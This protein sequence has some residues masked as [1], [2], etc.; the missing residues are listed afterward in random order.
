[1]ASLACD[2][3]VLLPALLSWHHAHTRCAFA[4]AQQ[5]FAVPAHVLMETF[6]VLTRLPGNRISPEGAAALIAGVDA[7]LIDLPACEHRRVI[8]ALGARGIGGGATYDALVAATAAHH[9]MTLLT[10]DLRAPRT[11]E[12]VGSTYRTV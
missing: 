3:S 10:S 5:E 12:A 6:S 9:G 8:A 1:M 11:Y 4:L 2:T 7:P